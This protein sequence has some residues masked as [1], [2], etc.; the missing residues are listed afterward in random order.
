[1][2]VS[3]FSNFSIDHILTRSGDLDQRSRSLDTNNN[4]TSPPGMGSHFYNSGHAMGLT[5]FR[6]YGMPIAL[7]LY[8]ISPPGYPYCTDCY[9]YGATL[10]NHP[11]SYMYETGKR[12]MILMLHLFLGFPLNPRFNKISLLFS[13]LTH[14]CFSCLHRA[15][16]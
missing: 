8:K 15:S 7:P 14:A 9:Y 12:P 3:R 16:V 10:P 4:G 6:A 11:D 1:M 2:E 5:E 13:S